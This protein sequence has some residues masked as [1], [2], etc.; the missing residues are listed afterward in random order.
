VCQGR[1]ITVESEWTGTH[2]VHRIPGHDKCVNHWCWCRGTHHA[3]ELSLHEWVWYI[4]HYYLILGASGDDYAFGLRK[5]AEM[6]LTRETARQV[7][8]PP[9]NATERR[10]A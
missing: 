8:D 4:R 6:G 10:A 3:A 7:L 9:T 1:I 2:W 5:L